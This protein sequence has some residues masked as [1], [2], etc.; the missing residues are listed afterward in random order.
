[1]KIKVSFD[2][3]ESRD[4]DV[5]DICRVPCVGEHLLIDED[6]YMGGSVF[7]RLNADPIT[8]TQAVIRVS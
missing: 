1:M 2:D 8:N 6:I 5:F 7:H 3:A 4:D